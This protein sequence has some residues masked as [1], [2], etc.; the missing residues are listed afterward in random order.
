MSDGIRAVERKDDRWEM[1]SSMNART[2]PA[3][4]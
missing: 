3:K 2:K 1:T 4:S